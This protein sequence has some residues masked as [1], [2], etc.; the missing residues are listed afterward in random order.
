MQNFTLSIENPADYIGW[1]RAN[2]K[3]Y[4]IA[5]SVP[6]GP[7]IN[8]SSI[9]KLD[10]HTNSLLG[11]YMNASAQTAIINHLGSHTGRAAAL[12]DA[13]EFAFNCDKA[14]ITGMSLN[15]QAAMMYSVEQKLLFGSF[16]IRNS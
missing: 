5:R 6:E 8:F 9:I 13:T 4:S 10:Q 16:T 2:N 1:D 12:T 15:E 7:V 3:P 11:K 14:I